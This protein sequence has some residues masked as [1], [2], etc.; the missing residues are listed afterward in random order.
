[1]A[2]RPCL[3]SL[4]AVLASC[5]PAPSSVPRY[6]GVPCRGPCERVILPECGHSP[7]RDK[8]LATLSAMTR[9]IRGLA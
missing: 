6:D 3:L 2:P 5:A 4:V 7:H 9:F 1:M 8:P